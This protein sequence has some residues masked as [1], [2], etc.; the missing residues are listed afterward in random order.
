MS[1]ILVHFNLSIKDKVTGPKSVHYSEVPQ[2]STVGGA[3]IVVL[4]LEVGAV[5]DVSDLRG[6]DKHHSIP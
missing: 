3:V 2:Y 4:R 1:I 5:D 6:G